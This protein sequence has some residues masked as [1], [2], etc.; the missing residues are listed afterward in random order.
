[1]VANINRET[2]KEVASRVL[3]RMQELIALMQKAAAEVDAG[4]ALQEVETG[5]YQLYIASNWKGHD[6][7]LVCALDLEDCFEIIY[8][9]ALEMGVRLEEMAELDV[10]IPKPEFGENMVTGGFEDFKGISVELR[11]DPLDDL[12]DEI[13]RRLESRGLTMT[14][15]AEDMIL[16]LPLRQRA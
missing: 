5:S 1:M 15:E 16:S 13:C 12:L 11:S 2:K 6:N 4:T 14:C 9:S 3:E 7:A 8:S 10:D